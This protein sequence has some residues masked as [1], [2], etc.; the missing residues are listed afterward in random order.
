MPKLS[1]AEVARYAGEAGF[2][3]SDIVTA[4]AIAFGESGGNPAA[5]NH[6][7]DKHRSTD[8]GLWQINNYWNPEI[9][10]SGS[11][12]NPADN[13][14]MAYAVYREQGFKAWYAY[15]NGSYLAHM[16]GAKAGAMKMAQ[17]KVDDAP[18]LGENTVDAI[19]GTAGTV[20]NIVGM[21]GKQWLAGFAGVALVIL[22]AYQISGSDIIG[23]AI[24][25]AAVA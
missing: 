1:Y 16:P 17:S 3:G 11:W 18:Q 8:F 7:T 24:K 15:T 6:N 4:T 10:A 5:V 12:S 25:I 9:L 13:A 22:A 23:K 2:R 21:S 20:G 14:R 19:R